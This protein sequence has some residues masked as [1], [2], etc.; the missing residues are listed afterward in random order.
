MTGWRTVYDA[1]GNNWIGKLITDIFGINYILYGT[2]N[3]FNVTCW[4]I[5]VALL[6]YV[7]TPFFCWILKKNPILLIGVGM[8]LGYD[9]FLFQKR[10]GLYYIV[11]FI[12]GMVLSKYEILDD[13]K[14]MKKDRYYVFG[15]VCFVFGMALI[16]HKFGIIMDGLFA[17]SIIIF[18]LGIIDTLPHIARGIG[19]V[20]KHATTIF[21]M[22]TFVFMYYF[23]NIIYGA[24][25]PSL[26]L[27]LLLLVC[28]IYSI[29]LKRIEIRITNKIRG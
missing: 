23:E 22:H 29:I 4:Y 1:Y 2:N 13:L 10:I 19:M 26:I 16:R 15:S 17:L 6:F 21:M 27:V 25:L 3:L 24:K 28:L 18:M 14:S 9:H 7:V 5:G 20:G 12:I 11:A 8:M